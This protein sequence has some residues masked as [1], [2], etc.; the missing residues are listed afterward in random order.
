MENL[1]LKKGKGKIV[2]HKSGGGKYKS[3]WIYIPKKLRE[4]ASFPFIENDELNIEIENGKLIVSKLNKILESIRAFGIENATVP[5]LIENKDVPQQTKEYIKDKIRSGMWLIKN[6][7]Q[8]QQ[9][10]FRI[11]EQIVKVQKRFFDEGIAFLKPLTMQEV[12]DALELHESTVSRAIANKYAQTPRGLFQLKYFFTSKI[13]TENGDATS[14]RSI[15][16]K[17][18]NI[19][20][21]ENKSNPLSI[22]LVILS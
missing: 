15:K 7:Y 5:K 2:T 12:A 1:V 19:I 9:T 8:R 16:Q 13:R 14:S 20:D 11:T 21:A 4:N 22:S 10:L 3:T 6:I 17:I 18:K